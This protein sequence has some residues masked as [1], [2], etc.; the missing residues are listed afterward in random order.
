M[1]DGFIVENPDGSPK[2]VYVREGDWVHI[3][4]SVHAGTDVSDRDPIEAIRKYE[5]QLLASDRH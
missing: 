1:A 5:I 4:E 2:R 3:A